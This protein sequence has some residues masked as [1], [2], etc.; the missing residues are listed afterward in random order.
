[1]QSLDLPAVH[2]HPPHPP[3]HI[4][5]IIWDKPQGYPLDMMQ[6]TPSQ[7]SLAFRSPLFRLRRTPPLRVFV[8]SVEMT[9]FRM[10][11]CKNAMKS[12]NPPQF[13]ILCGW[14][15]LLGTLPSEMKEA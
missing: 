9:G 12:V 14:E 4:P 6:Q 2:P 7:T 13:S 8:P 10:K 11:A 15:M 1:M 3:F 5:V